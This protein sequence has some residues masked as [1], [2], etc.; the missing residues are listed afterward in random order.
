MSFQ[1]DKNA[2]E[3]LAKAKLAEEAKSW[4]KELEKLARQM[5]GR[6][7]SEIKPKLQALM[8]KLGL[9]LEHA[10]IDYFAEAIEQ[11]KIPCFDA[12]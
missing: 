6:P 7:R 3:K 5:N 9:K 4:N 2:I 12:R 11:G 10:Q 8:N 1:I